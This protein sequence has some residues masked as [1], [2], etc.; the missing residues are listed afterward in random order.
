MAGGAHGSARASREM[1]GRGS[2]SSPSRTTTTLA[3]VLVAVA[4][5]AAWHRW[6][7][8]RG[9]ELTDHGAEEEEARRVVAETEDEAVEREIEAGLT[10]FLSRGERRRVGEHVEV[11]VF[12]CEAARVRIRETVVLCTGWSETMLKYGDLVKHLVEDR[13]VA[14]V[15]T[16]DHRAQG[17]SGPPRSTEEGHHVK[18]HVDD[19]AHHVEDAVRVVREVAMPLMPP[20]QGVVMAG[21]SLGGLVACRVT[22]AHPELVKKLVMF[23]PALLPKTGHD[24]RALHAVLRLARFVG[25]GDRFVPGHPSGVS[26]T[27]RLP[28]HSR[29][30]SSVARTKF[31]ER[32]RRDYPQSNING[33]SI[34]HL[35]E[36]LGAR[37][38][39]ASDFALVRVPT[40]LVSAGLDEFVENEPIFSMARALPSLARHLHFPRA[41]HEVLQERVEIRSECVRAVCRFLES[42]SSSSSSSS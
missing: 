25:F 12:T 40:L 24:P 11:A 2:S 13:G 42:S 10:W 38:D 23:C 41:K 9:R 27:L 5:A 39:S 26:H 14:A 6:R 3:A 29:V 36:I 30:T 20:G 1:S 31:W 37:V 18:S 35:C 33:M 8:S 4:V 17:L 22:M 21:F 34:S 7:R 16:M 19:F 28:P 15:V 32:L